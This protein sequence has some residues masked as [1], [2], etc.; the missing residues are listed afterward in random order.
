V[1]P[2]ALP[3]TRHGRACSLPAEVLKSRLSKG[4]HELLVVWTGLPVADATWMDLEEFKRLYMEFQL[5]DEMNVQDGRDVMW[6][7]PYAC[8]KKKAQTQAST[9]KEHDVARSN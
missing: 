1:T 5:K 9:N 4:H 2:G 7:I 8:R 3:P 6:R